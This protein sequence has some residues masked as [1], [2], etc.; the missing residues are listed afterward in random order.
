MNNTIYKTLS[1]EQIRQINL[2]C[3]ILKSRLMELGLF[4]TFREMDKVTK[5]IGWETSEI[6]E[7]KH[8]V[9]LDTR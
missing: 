7:G 5:K 3:V 6:I 4:Q 9:K 1:Y 2:E 8:P